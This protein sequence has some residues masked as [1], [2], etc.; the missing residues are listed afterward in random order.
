M[1]YIGTEPTAGQYRKL[2]NIAG[3]FNGSTTTFT[4]QV[5][6][7]NVSAGSASQL[8]VSLGGVIQQP[9]TD[10]T[11]STNSITFTTAPASGLSFFGVLM[12]DAINVGTPS[13]GTVTGAKLSSNFNYNSGLLYLDSSNNRVGIGSTAPDVNLVVEAATGDATL[14]VHAAENNSGSEP[15]LILESSND[16]AESIIDFKDSSGTG[17]SIRYNHGDNALRFLANGAERTR[18]DSSGRL[19]VGTSTSPSAGQG[20]YSKL[21]ALG[22]AG[23]S[24]GNVSFGNTS[25]A[26]SLSSGD[27]VA[28]VCFT[29]NTGNVFSRIDCAVDATPGASD[30]PGRLVFST[31]A[32]GASSPTERMRIT[33]TGRL[34]IART[35][36]GTSPAYVNIEHNSSFAGIC[37]DADSTSARTAIRF[38][39]PNGNVGFVQTSGS[40]T[41]YSTSSDY[42]L[43]ENIAPVA[44]G[45]NRLQQLNPCRFNFI[46]DSAKVLDGFI[47][48]EVQVVVPEAITG[49]KDAVDADGNPVY[50]GIDQSK[51]VPLLTAALQEAVGRIETLETEVAALKAQ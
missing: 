41:T 43:K 3:S 2:D 31:T 17:G 13:D 15:I 26:T 40:T 10:Y 12:G 42:R 24:Y 49:E 50:Q 48:H 46:A 47:A 21:V 6:G 45:I 25:A 4:M 34:N 16:F 33:Q 5:G 44:D 18:I 51:L 29:D 1:A 8:I 35:S 14:R 37:L 22:G 39:N 19:L 20:Q 27:N 11:V 38:N 23:T 32:D 9:G 36:D 30:F 28:L 7:Q